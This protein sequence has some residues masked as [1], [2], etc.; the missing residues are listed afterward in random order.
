MIN[1]L[2]STAVVAALIAAAP[3]PAAAQ[4]YQYQPGDRVEC[5]LVGSAAP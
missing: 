3:Q 2:F 1:R 4:G 5:N